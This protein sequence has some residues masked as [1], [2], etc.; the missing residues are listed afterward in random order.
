MA[1]TLHPRE[2][3]GSSHHAQCKP[4]AIMPVPHASTRGDSPADIARGYRPIALALLTL[5]LVALCLV[6]VL[7]FLPAL[8]WGVA[9]AVIAWPLQSWMLQY[10]PRRS[11]ATALTTGIVLVLIVG[12][13]LFMVYHL[14]RETASTAEQIRGETTETT[15]RD[16]LADTPGMGAAVAWLERVG[17][18]VDREIHRAIQ[19]NTREL[20]ALVQ[21]S[22]LGIVQFAVAMF[23][24]FHIL[25]D[26]AWLQT[27]ARELLPMS[28]AEGDQV[29]KSAADSVHANLHATLITSVIDGLGGGF[30]FWLLG[31]PSPVTWGVVMFFLS[32]LPLLGTWIVWLPAALV[33]GL[34]GLWLNAFGLLMWGIASSVVVDNIIYVRIAGERMRLHQVPAL[35]AFLGGLAVFGVS[36]MIL[37]PAILAVTVAV[38]DVWHQRANGTAPFVEVSSPSSEEAVQPSPNGAP[39]LR[40][41]VVPS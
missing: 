14:S 20:T 35:L 30:M 6:L 3:L 31:L 32:F 22:L 41:E 24:L 29:L 2:R 16:K 27:R 40:P 17:V 12:P 36:G 5:A 18:N 10:V 37:G 28:R 21:G 1:L 39:A 33:L 26:R 11:L 7:P 19:E 8:A 25:L 9:L 13:G 4:E 15:V 38:L 23:I 34:S